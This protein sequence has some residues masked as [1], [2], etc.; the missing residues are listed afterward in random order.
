MY[1]DCVAFKDFILTFFVS[2][3]GDGGEG[4]AFPAELLA[5]G[6]VEGVVFVWE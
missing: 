1:V 2:F 3:S 6:G 4:G 5:E